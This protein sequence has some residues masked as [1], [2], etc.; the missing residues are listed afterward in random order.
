[1]TRII[2]TGAS[3]LVG[4]ET[5]RRALD[6][7][8]VTAV[9]ALVRRPLQISHPKL[10]IVIHKDFLNYDLLGD[11]FA[12]HDAC[13]WCLGI[14]QSRVSASEYFI[15]THDYALAAATAAFHFNPRMV[16]SFVSAMGADPAGRFPLRFARV[17]RADR[18]RTGKCRTIST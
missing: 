14:S 8:Q 1:M 6:H 15:I 7:G 18:V 12:N 4:S 13:I 2:I 5:L 17:E 10:K 16:F 3:G 9:T 11:L